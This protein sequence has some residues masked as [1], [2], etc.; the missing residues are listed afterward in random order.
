MSPR[1]VWRKHPIHRV[2]QA[3]KKYQEKSGA[4]LL[5]TTLDP[6]LAGSLANRLGVLGKTGILFGRTPPRDSGKAGQ[7]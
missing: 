4:A 3:L 5:F 7:R 2:I 6:T 1:Q